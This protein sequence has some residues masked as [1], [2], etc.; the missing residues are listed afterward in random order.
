MDEPTALPE[1]SP[2]RSADPAAGTTHLTQAELERQVEELSALL[3]ALEALTA[4]R[5]VDALIQVSLS[6]ITRQIPYSHLSVYRAEPEGVRILAHMTR[7]GPLPHPPHCAAPPDLVAACLQEHRSI[8]VGEVYSGAQYWPALPGARSGMAVPVH[9]HG[10]LWG[11]VAVSADHSG[12]YRAAEQRLLERIARSVGAALTPLLDL[13]ALRVAYDQ[14]I[15]GWARALD[16]RHKEPEGHAARVAALTVQ[17][18]RTVGVPEEELPH[19]FRGALLH[20]IGQMNIP[21]RILLKAGALDEDEWRIVR[22]HPEM[23]LDLL[24]PIAL[25][26]PALDIPRAHHEKWDGSG[27][28]QGLRGEEIPL[29]ARVFAVVDV[30]EALLHDRPYRR[31][32][33]ERRALEFIQEQS[34]VHFDPHVVQAFVSIAHALPPRTR[35]T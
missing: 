13:E 31:A 2:T 19:V 6:L 32:W 11:V 5:S 34:G 16:Y 9:V 22:L 10:A 12:V 27:Y 7:D 18:A 8:R 33:T 23:A 35:R 24:E 14:T 3:G 30:W 29:A 28:P 25:L 20:D 4:S 15:A 21:D 1:L 17:L 26:R